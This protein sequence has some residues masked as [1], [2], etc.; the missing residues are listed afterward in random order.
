MLAAVAASLPRWG[1]LARWDCDE[2]RDGGLDTIRHCTGPLPA[3]P[4]AAPIIHLGIAPELW[5]PYCPFRT[6]RPWEFP[7]VAAWLTRFARWQRYGGLGDP[8]E[9]DERTLRAFDLMS[10]A[11]RLPPIEGR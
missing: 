1:K 8:D 5:L 2:C 10:Y 4:D 3:E 7:D 11:L 9:Q 6:L